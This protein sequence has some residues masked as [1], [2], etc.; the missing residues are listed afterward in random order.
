M[1]FYTDIQQSKKLVEIGVD[2]TTAD[3]YY[4]VN[5][6]EIKETPDNLLGTILDKD[7]PCWSLDALLKLLPHKFSNK[8]YVES[9]YD[10]IECD[11]NIQYL[12]NGYCI[13]YDY[14]YTHEH[15]PAYIKDRKT[16]VSTH[17]KTELVDAAFE[18]ITILNKIAC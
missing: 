7:I 9:V 2:I 10:H 13:T 16:L 15:G 1:K 4:D 6:D 5:N 14:D 18:M 17:T 11:L 3:M 8:E 12:E